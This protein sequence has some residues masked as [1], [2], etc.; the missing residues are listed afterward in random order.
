VTSPP[1][2]S[3][4][5]VV[6]NYDGGDHLMRCLRSVQAAAGDATLEVVVVDN[7]SHDGSHLRAREAFPSIRVL[8]GSVNV[9]FAAGA[10]RGIEATTAPLIFLLN[11]D[12]E[13]THGTLGGLVKLAADRPGVG[14]LG[15]SI[16]N[17]DGTFDPPGRRVPSPV[18]GLGHVVLG[19]VAPGNRFSRA[20]LETRR[21]RGVEAD[22]DWV[23]GG[24]MLLRRRAL[25][26]VGLFDEGFFMYVEDVDL[27]TRLRRAGWAVRY[28]PEVEVLHVSGLATRRDPR[29]PL[30]HSRSAYRYIR[31]HVL[32]GWKA[33]LLPFAWVALRMRAAVVG[34][35]WGR[36]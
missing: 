28:S 36:S 16:R 18:E 2:P 35:S 15:V 24:A 22:V 17:T 14:A 10:N 23:S 7:A 27:C 4:A 29:M 26:D 8:A 3:L 11:P 25:D 31:K 6:V 13:V 20:Y 21:D 34:R 9:G 33:P 1:G 12:A 5:V 19:P 30:M 32:T